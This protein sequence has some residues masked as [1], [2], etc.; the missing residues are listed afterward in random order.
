MKIL[1]VADR[2]EFNKS[3][4]LNNLQ[5]RFNLLVDELNKR[6][7]PIRLVEPFNTAIDKVNNYKGSI[8]GL[9]KLFNE[10]KIN[11]LKTLE[12]EL[13][14]V[15]QKTYL[16]RWL[17]IGMAV[18]GIPIGIAYGNLFDNMAFLGI[19]LPIGMVIGMAIGAGMDKK[20]KK[21][22]RQLDVDIQ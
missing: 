20:A 14:I 11:I 15:P 18:F 13:K 6:N 22:G 3:K 16:T 9:R 4:K 1:K 12:K 2:S 5:T 17:A 7:I 8:G 10:V 21:E 19:G